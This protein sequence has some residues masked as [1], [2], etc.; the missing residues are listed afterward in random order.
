MAAGVLMALE[1]LTTPTVYVLIPTHNGGELLLECLAYLQDQTYPAS[2]VIVIDDGSTDGTAEAVRAAF[3]TTTI[4]TGDGSL[5]WTGA[6]ALGVDHVLGLAKPS[7]FVLSLNHDVSF[8]PGY[9]ATLVES[10]DQCGRAVVGSFCR[11]ADNGV[12]IDQGCRMDWKTSRRRTSVDLLRDELRRRGLPIDQP[13]RTAEDVLDEIDV[14]EGFDW[15]YGRG[16]L[17][18]VE[19]FGQAG[20]F[21]G[22]RF[23]HYG[24]DTEFFHRAGQAGAKLVVSLRARIANV[25]TEETTGVHHRRRPFLTIREAW[26]VLTSQRSAYQLSKS[27][28]FVERCCPKPYR[29]RNKLV[30]IRACLA[31]S[32]GRTWPVRL[33]SWPIRQIVRAARRIAC[34]SRE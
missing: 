32:F 17:I 15:L 27:L 13:E 20:N 31:R 28:R 23:P 29:V 9:L 25:E 2:E 1:A 21:D 26:A 14:L 3:P 12:I 5:W 6:M 22:R 16:T 8:E 34:R 18:P 24:G 30:A 4:L 11:R 10:S 7:D 33:A 19:V